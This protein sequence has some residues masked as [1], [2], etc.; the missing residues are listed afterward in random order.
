MAA[1]DDAIKSCGSRLFGLL[2]REGGTG[3]NPTWRHVYWTPAIRRRPHPHL[4]CVA[5]AL[6]LSA[7]QQLWDEWDGQPRK[8]PSRH[9]T[10]GIAS[11]YVSREESGGVSSRS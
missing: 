9:H 1:F 11:R 8:A 7:L 4:R 10:D 3:L 5:W 6:A 2:A